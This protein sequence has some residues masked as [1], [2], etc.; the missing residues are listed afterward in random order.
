[1]SFTSVEG[2]KS[3][4]SVSGDSVTWFL[5]TI[6]REP[7]LTAAEEI[8]LGNHIQNMM[9]ILADEKTEYSEQEARAI[10]IKE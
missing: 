2:D 8:E 7:L 6:C 1:M 3:T 9:K 5:S 4:R 10:R